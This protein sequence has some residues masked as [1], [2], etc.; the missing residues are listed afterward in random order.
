MSIFARARPTKRCV[1]VLGISLYALQSSSERWLSS[2]AIRFDL[3]ALLGESF[4]LPVA[5]IQLL[6]QRLDGLLAHTKSYA[7]REFEFVIHLL[8]IGSQ[9]CLEVVAS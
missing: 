6:K 3:L 7:F 1:Q 4:Q 2:L 8:R 9:K 5:V